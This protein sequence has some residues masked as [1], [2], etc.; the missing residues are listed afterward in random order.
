VGE[1]LAA[2]HGRDVREVAAITTENARR[3]FRLDSQPA[4]QGIA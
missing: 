1:Q 4:P 2:L 3:L